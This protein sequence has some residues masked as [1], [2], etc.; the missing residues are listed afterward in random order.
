MATLQKIRDKSW[1]LVTVIG[2]ALLAFVFMDGASSLS[3]GGCNSNPVENIGKVAGI[4]IS[5]EDFEKKLAQ[6]ERKKNILNQ[7][8]NDVSLRN[9]AWDY[10]VKNIIMEKEF[11]KIGLDISD[12]EWVLRIKD[13]N[14]VHQ[15][16]NT[17][18]KDSSGIYNGEL[19]W[20]QIQQIN[21]QPDGDPNKRLWSDCEEIILFDWKYEKY[22]TLIGQ[23]M[24]ATSHEA[25][26]N[27]L[28]SKQNAIFDY[29]AIPYTAINNEDITVTDNEI[30][31]YYSKN[32][33]KYKQE[34]SNDVDLVFFTAEPSK[35]DDERAK[36]LLL[37]AITKLENT[38]EYVDFR[39]NPD[40][41]NSYNYVYNTADISEIKWQE[42]INTEA[43][44]QFQMLVD[45]HG[46]PQALQEAAGAPLEDLRMQIFN[47]FNFTFE[48]IRNQ[49][50]EARKGL[51]TEQWL[52]LFNSEE[53]TVIGP[54]LVKDGLYRIAKNASVEFRSDSVEIRHIMIS[55]P[56]PEQAG[57]QYPLLVQKAEKEIDSIKLLIES[58]IDFFADPV[59][60]DI[61]DDII[62]K[63]RGGN[64]GWITESSTIFT[65]FGDEAQKFNDSCFGNETGSLLKLKSG[66]GYHLVQITNKSPLVRKVKV[67]YADSEVIISDETKDNYLLQA[68][69]FKQDLSK[70]KS[71]LDE[72]VVKYNALKRSAKGVKFTDQDILN[73]DKSR[74]II[75][76]LYKNETGSIS[77]ILELYNSNN[78]IVVAYFVKKNQDGFSPLKDVKEQIKS[79]IIKEKKASKIKQSINIDLGLNDIAKMYS[80]NVISGYSVKFDTSAK[81]NLGIEPSFSG[82]V[83]GSKL[84]TISSPIIGKN[85][86]YVINVTSIDTTSFNDEEVINRKAFLRKGSDFAA[87]YSY[88]A[89]K[90]AV[91]IIDQRILFY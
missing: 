78:D 58:G 10:Y 21:M 47:N 17:L 1:L 43:S 35:S 25:K 40:Y 57:E 85:G 87:D 60:M 41:A 23:S 91:E 73:I 44:R 56:S 42:I 11:E 39:T 74:Q 19:A 15:I 51:N 55:L 65:G 80:T 45:F 28:A 66:Y 59:A 20:A 81:L 90:D 72:L 36:A 13:N 12:E 2:V 18:F 77:D 26:D 61:S 69:K 67:V 9:E 3:G 6:I 8:Y 30:K 75:Q 53:G 33:G 4:D 84:N 38:N 22:L 88:D 24:Y 46:S 82:N 83:F 70:N 76:W 37:S 62:T 14:N 5:Q 29:V 32:K 7:T 16:L 27:L 31:S 54:Y 49:K 89:I 79:L 68:A 52:D 50:N 34:A 86:I 71:N 48:N 63:K 64:L